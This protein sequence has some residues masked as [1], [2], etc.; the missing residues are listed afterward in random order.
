MSAMSSHK[1]AANISNLRYFLPKFRN[2]ACR[3]AFLNEMAGTNTGPKVICSRS[4]ENG[5]LAQR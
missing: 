3:M 2:V 5:R 1:Y 4:A